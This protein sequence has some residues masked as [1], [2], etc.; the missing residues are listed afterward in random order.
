[1][2]ARVGNR[3]ESVGWG[4]LNWVEWVVVKCF[5][6]VGKFRSF[7]RLMDGLV[8]LCLCLCNV[9]EV[10]VG[11]VIRQWLCRIQVGKCKGLED[12][13]RLLCIHL[14][15][16]SIIALSN[17]GAL[18]LIYFQGSFELEQMLSAGVLARLGDLSFVVIKFTA[19]CD[20]QWAT[21]LSKDLLHPPTSRHQIRVESLICTLES[22]AILVLHY[23]TQ[24]SKAEQSFEAVEAY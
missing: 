13:D 19:W 2:S 7:V 4:G 8:L 11:R 24:V 16:L 15:T 20:L 5:F 14:S 21:R 10:G 3:N 6:T 17:W 1:M 9:I 12:V 18:L 22:L 23:K